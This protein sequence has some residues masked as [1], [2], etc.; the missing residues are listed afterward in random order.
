MNAMRLPSPNPAVNAA[1]LGLF[2]F[3]GLYSVRGRL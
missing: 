2:F 1:G 3:P